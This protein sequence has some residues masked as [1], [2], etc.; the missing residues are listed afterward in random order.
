MKQDLNSGSSPVPHAPNACQ[1]SFRVYACLTAV[2]ICTLCAATKAERGND[3]WAIIN[4]HPT[5]ATESHANSVTCG[6]QVGDAVVEGHGRAS[7]WTGTAASWVHLAPGTFSSGAFGGACGQQVGEYYSNMRTAR[8]WST[9]PSS[10]VDLHPAGTAES[11]AHATDGTQQ[12]GRASFG[13]LGNAQHASLWT[14]TAASWVDLNP[15]GSTESGAWGV[16]GGQQVGYANVDG[17]SRASLWFGTSE[18]WV[19]LNPA[20]SSAS[21][22]LGVFGGQQ[23]GRANVGGENRASLW[24]GTSASW[25]DLSPIVSAGPSYSHGVHSGRQVGFVTVSS[26]AH[27][28]LWRGTAESWVNLHEFLPLGFSSSV[29][30]SIWCDGATTYVV[31]YGYNTATARTEAI[32]WVKHCRADY[33]G[34]GTLAVPDIFAFLAVWF[35]GDVE[36][37][38]FNQDCC[39]NVQDIFAFLFAWFAG[40][41]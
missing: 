3:E 25:V 23:V 37:A 8:I 5:G 15:A 13:I 22:A 21:E 24:T 14:G 28:S 17:I 4:L 1:T 18:S 31:G 19:D 7:L 29:A 35:G 16:S 39:V 10:G 6:Q 12:V 27:A 33:D 41:S 2:A 38:N 34:N 11:S 26:A 40:C 9:E 30:R 20:G 36:L 32:M